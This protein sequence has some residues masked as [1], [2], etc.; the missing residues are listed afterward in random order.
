MPARGVAPATAGGFHELSDPGLPLAR[1]RPGVFP[2]ETTQA[3]SFVGR[4]AIA[5]VSPVHARPAARRWSRRCFDGYAFDRPDRSMTAPAPHRASAARTAARRSSRHASRPIAT[6]HGASG[7]CGGRRR[8]R[9]APP[10]RSSMYGHPYIY[11]N[12]FCVLSFC[13]LPH[14]SRVPTP[15]R[16]RSATALLA[17]AAGAFPCPS[18]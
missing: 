14:C 16:A 18:A 17:R 13:P 11:Y 1:A 7:R 10:L 4:V 12:R 15:A 6:I 3:Q 9:S 8:A 2:C 5:C